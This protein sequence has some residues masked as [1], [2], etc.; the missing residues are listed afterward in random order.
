MQSKLVC[1]SFFHVAGSGAYGYELYPCVA[2]LVGSILLVLFN[3]AGGPGQLPL[4][5]WTGLSIFSP[6]L[7]RWYFFS[8]PQPH[9][10][11]DR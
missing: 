9:L 11:K 7:A 3:F 1:V 10:L 2:Q 4:L 5:T 6:G 8:H